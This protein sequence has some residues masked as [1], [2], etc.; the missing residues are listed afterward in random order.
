MIS[1]LKTTSA[2]SC[3]SK[4]N[5]RYSLLLHQVVSSPVQTLTLVNQTVYESG[6]YK[7]TVIFLLMIPVYKH[8]CSSHQSYNN[9][10]LMCRA[11]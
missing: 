8:S 4:C 7:N 9:K 11:A 2:T 1:V 10:V 3:K 5:L 6:L